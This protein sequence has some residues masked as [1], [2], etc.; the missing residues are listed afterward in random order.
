MIISVN[1]EEKHVP[2]SLEMI[3]LGKF[4]EWYET[5]GSKLDKELQEILDKEY[6]H[7]LQ[8]E[9]AIEEHLLNEAIAWY[10][11]FTGYDFSI[12]KNSNQGD[13]LLI[14]YKIIRGLLKEHEQNTTEFPTKI[15][16]NG[17]DWM[18]QNFVVDPKSEMTFNEIITS[19]EVMRQLHSLGLGKWHSLLYLS[20]IF[21]RKVDEPFLD[22]LIYEDGERM[23]QLRNLPMNIAMTVGFFLRSCVD[24]WKSTFQFS[25]QEEAQVT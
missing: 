18:I 4:I 1:G 14:Q 13:E 24:T 11:Y 20:C 16:W 5:Y 25:S 8:L 22:E 15:Q 12:V 6:D 7:E 21:F 10:S 17:E 2:S 23:N 19:K 9:F 3:T